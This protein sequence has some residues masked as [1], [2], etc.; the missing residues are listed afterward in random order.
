[1]A[2]N[3]RNMDSDEEIKRRQKSR[4]VAVALCVAAFVVIVFFVTIIRIQMGIDASMNG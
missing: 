4:N 1:M 2:D 3:D